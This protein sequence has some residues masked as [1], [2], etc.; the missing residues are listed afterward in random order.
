MRRFFIDQA[1]VSGDSATIT[2]Q[3]ARHIST[4]LRLKPGEAIEL[5]DGTGLVYQTEILSINKSTIKAK[6]VERRCHQ[7]Q[8]PFLHLAQALVKGKKMDLIIQK[9][10]ELGVASFQPVVTQHCDIK[11]LPN[12]QTDRWQRIS[13][14]ACK[15][16]NRPTPMRFHPTVSF[17]QFAALADKSA[18]KIIFWEN[19]ST[20]PALTQQ[21]IAHNQQALI[22]IGPEGGFTEDEVRTAIQQGFISTTLG[23]RIL[24][25]ETAAIAAIS[26]VQFLLGNLKK[27]ESTTEVR[28]HHSQKLDFIPS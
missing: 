28:T 22:L 20:S 14:E 8:A 12:G 16:C 24:R 13:L 10:T 17:D 5:F 2:D 4:V 26:I 9:A 11:S 15:Q 19:D 3:E 18:T 7:E 6:I 23:P 27:P 21:F 25:A 1:S